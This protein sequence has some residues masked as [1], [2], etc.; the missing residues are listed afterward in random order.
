MTADEA[1]P[2][3]LVDQ[4]NATFESLSAIRKKRKTPAGYATLS[5]IKSFTSQRSIPSLHA[6]SPAGITALAVSRQDPARFLT[7]GNDKVV[8]LYDRNTDKVIASLKGH[9]KKITHVALR[10]HTGHPTLLLSAGADKIAK[11]WTH[12]SNADA[13]M[14]ASTIRVHKGELTGL[15][16]HPISTLVA[17]AS[18][19]KTYSLHDL[20]TMESVFRSE[21]GED[22]FTALG[23]HPDGTL[24]AVGTAGS[25]I[26]IYDTRTGMIAASFSGVEEGDGAKPFAVNTVSFSENGYYLL[27]P[28]APTGAVAVWDLRKQ[29]TARTLNVGSSFKVNRVLCDLGAVMYGVAGSEGI[30][31]YSSKWEELLKLDQAGDVSDMAFG[32]HGKEIWAT[33]GREVKIWGLPE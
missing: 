15:A 17:Y 30:R 21:P 26:H 23:V 24:L 4:I 3:A 18:L 25:A 14:P 13:Y 7:G 27:A 6:S 31:V 29:K 8:Q 2:K 33:A 28:G 22:A 5:D 12:D 19:D 11:I 1:L 9:T 32:L 20:T 16:V 10:E